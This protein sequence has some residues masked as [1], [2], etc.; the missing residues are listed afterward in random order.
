[1]VEVEENI[2]TVKREEL[3]HLFSNYLLEEFNISPLDSVI[4]VANSSF[5]NDFF[6]AQKRGIASRYRPW[7]SLKM[8]STGLLSKLSQGFFR[9]RVR[10]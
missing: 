4:T 10:Y 3:M 9:L 5:V 2:E 1:M 7:I 8:I 6:E